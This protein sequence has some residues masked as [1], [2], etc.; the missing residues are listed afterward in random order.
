[1]AKDIYREHGIPTP[2]EV[3]LYKGEGYDVVDLV[4]RVGL[5]AFVKPVSKWVEL[6]QST[7]ATQAS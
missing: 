4:G 3:C 6:R 5:P 7:R 1:M 2:K